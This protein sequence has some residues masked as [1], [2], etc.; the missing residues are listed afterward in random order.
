MNRGRGISERVFHA[1]F[2]ARERGMTVR[3]LAAYAYAD[4]QDG[5]PLDAPNSIS[6]LIHHL[7]RKYLIPRG[8]RIIADSDRGGR[9]ARRKLVM[10]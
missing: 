1:L 4:D 5:G 9:Y 6:V 10:L 3:E 2:V 8:A 7:N